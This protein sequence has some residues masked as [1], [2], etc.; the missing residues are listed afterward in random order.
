[1]PSCPVCLFRISGYGLGFGRCSKLC[2]LRLQLEENGNSEDTGYRG[3][4][5]DKYMW[6][7]D[8]CKTCE[9]TLVKRSAASTLA[10]NDCLTEKE[11]EHSSHAG[12]D[13]PVSLWSCLTCGNVGCGRYNLKHA[14]HHFR[15]SGHSMSLDVSSGRV[16]DYE[17]DRFVQKDDLRECEGL[18]EEG[19]ECADEDGGEKE[20]G[21][22]RDN[23][24]KEFEVLLQSALEDQKN[25]FETELEI[26]EEDCA[27]RLREKN[28]RDKMKEEEEKEAERILS[29]ISKLEHELENIGQNIVQVQKVSESDSL[30]KTRRGMLLPAFR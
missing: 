4:Q 8:S 18:K 14:Q 1:M 16:W 27:R 25:W 17:L 22:K 12:E 26:V 3:C 5:K 20:A 29:S 6:K 10:C 13:A 23:V 11:D 15:N 21:A 7:W 2:A 9:L 24:K 28:E 30:A 19:A